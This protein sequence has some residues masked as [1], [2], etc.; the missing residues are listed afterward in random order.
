MVDRS[1]YWDLRLGMRSLLYSIV[2]QTTYHIMYD[3]DYTLITL[4]TMSHTRSCSYQSRRRF[5]C[6][7]RCLD[8]GSRCWLCSRLFCCRCNICRCLLHCSSNYCIMQCT[9]L[10]SSCNN[11]HKDWKQFPYYSKYQILSESRHSFIQMAY[12]EL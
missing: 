10:N 3:N 11:K 7:G 2:V 4:N 1:H 8:G 9:A 5:N 6:C 12:N